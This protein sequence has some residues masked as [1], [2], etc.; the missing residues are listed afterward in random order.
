MGF[1]KRRQDVELFYGY[2][3]GEDGIYHSFALEDPDRTPDDKY[4]GDDMI[5]ERL[6]YDLD[7]NVDDQRFNWD[8]MF[9]TLP[10]SVV[11]RI[12]AEGRNE[13][14]NDCKS[15]MIREL[16][17]RISNV[18]ESLRFRQNEMESSMRVLRSR[19]Q[20]ITAEDVL[21]GHLDSCANEVRVAAARVNEQQAMIEALKAVKD[22]VQKG[23]LK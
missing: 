14:I 23:E 22:A 13:A 11:E 21:R 15:A 17:R 8:S 10:E 2:Q 1:A 18:E 5:A 3:A 7:T 19:V 6:A 9:V 20:E 16:E 12:K 4:E